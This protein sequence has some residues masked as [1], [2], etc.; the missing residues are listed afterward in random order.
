MQLTLVDPL[1]A[2][3]MEVNIKQAYQAGLSNSKP[4]TWQ[5]I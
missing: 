3:Y 1:P 5:L 4:P 2:A